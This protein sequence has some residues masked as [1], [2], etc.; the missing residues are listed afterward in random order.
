MKESKKF[1]TELLLLTGIVSLFMGASMW[2]TWR[3]GWYPQSADWKGPSVHLIQD[4]DCFSIAVLTL[5]TFVCLLG[6]IKGLGSLPDRQIFRKSQSFTDPPFSFI[7]F[8]LM[9]AWFPFFLVFFPG[10]GMNDT[11]DILRAEF[12]AAGQHTLLY[13]LF[14]GGLGEISKTLTGNWAAGLAAASIV[15]MY[16]L[17][18]AIAYVVTWLYRRSGSAVLAAVFTAYYAF[19]P[20]IINYSFANVKDTLFSAAVLLWIPLIYELLTEGEEVFPRMERLFI[21]ASLGMLLLRNNGRYVYA[22]LLLLFL[23]TF[24]KIRWKAASLGAALFL[25]SLLPNAAL[26]YFMNLPQLF[27][28]RVGVPIQQVGRVIAAGRPLLPEEEQY[29]HI[30]MDPEEMRY[31][32]DP[33]T[34]DGIKWNRNFH[35]DS[36]NS[37]SEEFWKTWKSLGRRYPKDFIEGWMLAVYGYWSFPAPDG[38]TQS[39][40]G[41]AFSM[42]DL[43]APWGMDPASNNDYQTGTML[44]VYSPEMQEKLGRYLWNHSR[45]AGAG[46]CFWITVILALVLLYRRRGKM[47]LI[48][49]PAFLLWGTLLLA[50]PAAF[51]FR[52]VFYFPLCLPFFLLLPYM[53]YKKRRKEN[54]WHVLRP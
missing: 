10:T 49:M 40:F 38:E 24:H 15:Q 5:V 31:W 30:M 1:S 19:C 39:R 9:A 52:Y 28:E 22:V 42:K 12:W 17:A 47:L 32:Y 46:S 11:T 20:M 18:G 35:F 8:L 41:W 21:I 27:Q 14:L 25:L 7:V 26:S 4:G 43:T 45:Y 48:L 6:I 2:Y 36:F 51:V 54:P 44:H 34:A 33:F 13:C 23:L 53:P 16:L 37:H 50:A 29:L 3:I